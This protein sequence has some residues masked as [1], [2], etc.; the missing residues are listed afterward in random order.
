[1]YKA[2]PIVGGTNLLQTATVDTLKDVLRELIGVDTTTPLKSE[3]FEVSKSTTCPRN[4]LRKYILHIRTN[5]GGKCDRS[6]VRGLISKI[7]VEQ[8]MEGETGAQVQCP[9]MPAMHLEDS[10]KE[11][12]KES[13][14]NHDP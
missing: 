1:M 11:D 14:G 2:Y 4:G 6:K 8:R 5:I 9:Q 12:M 10:G 13:L 3:A 7:A